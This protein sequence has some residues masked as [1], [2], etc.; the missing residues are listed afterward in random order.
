MCIIRTCVLSVRQTGVMDST[1][2]ST[3]ASMEQ[4]SDNLTAVQERDI[5]YDSNY[6][7]KDTLIDQ[8]IPD[9]ISITRDDMITT[10]SEHVITS[11]T[12]GAI[13]NYTTEPPLIDFQITQS[14]PTSVDC[15]NISQRDVVNSDGYDNETNVHI[16]TDLYDTTVYSS[17]AIDASL[18]E[19]SK[20]PH[21]STPEVHNT[22]YG[23]QEPLIVIDSPADP[24]IFSNQTTCI[25]AAQV[26]A[27]M[28][29]S[30]KE[31][32]E[33]NETPAQ[34][35]VA[36]SVINTIVD[37]TD[38]KE[39]TSNDIDYM[40]NTDSSFDV[41]ES[42]PVY[43]NPI[44]IEGY[45][46]E[47]CP[48]DNVNTYD[49]TSSYNSYTPL[50]ET[51]IA[52]EVPVYTGYTPSVSSDNHAPTTTGHV[53]DDD[54]NSYNSETPLIDPNLPN[55]PFPLPT[56]AQPVYGQQ[57]AVDDVTNKLEEPDLNSLYVTYIEDITGNPPTVNPFQSALDLFSEQQAGTNTPIPVIGGGWE[58]GSICS[59]NLHADV[60]ARALEANPV[61]DRLLSR[62]FSKT[63]GYLE[64][65][66]QKTP[67]KEGFTSVGVCKEQVDLIEDVKI[68][69][70]GNNLRNLLILSISMTLLHI[71][72]YGLRNL[73]SSL[74]TEA[75]LGV[76]SLAATFAAFMIGSLVSPF[77][78]KR[79][80]PRC[81]LCLA[82]SGHLPYI[83]A[84]YYPTFSTMI[85]SSALMGF[86]SAVVWNAICTYITEIGI[87]ESALK[88]KNVGN[89]LSRYF[90]IFFL[91]LQLSVVFGNLI[92][93]IVL[94]SSFEQEDILS[95]TNNISIVF[96]NKTVAAPRHC[97][98]HECNDIIET[99]GKPAVDNMDKL[100]L[101]G[102]YSGCTVI[103]IIVLFLFL[104]PLPSF[105]PQP[106]KASN[107]LRGVGNIVAMVI[108]RKFIF[109]VLLCLY[110]VFSNGFVIAD[111]LKVSRRY[112][113]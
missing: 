91:V 4:M 25:D 54:T 109:I 113:C 34:L 12:T 20:W 89:V 9:E 95:E 56:D 111:V 100:L 26:F 77:L 108:D 88:K 52:I 66:Q 97:G 7:S 3:L 21:S 98:I 62:I 6:L 86:S 73:Q 43:V 59:I 27:N 5:I 92:S 79:F 93:S 76:Y 61:Q 8:S 32:V 36:C 104:D 38:D 16:S 68:P 110:T 96:T 11:P 78:V 70:K 53:S 57:L 85:L 39:Q 60:A 83:V 40:Y 24:S 14:I 105:L 47:D 42:F 82:T 101:L 103:A 87:N 99:G 45:S 13:N 49:G 67:F 33:P 106:I 10:A 2:T 1:L 31:F 102:S 71:A 90:G 48:Q 112:T 22:F 17:T 46:D 72:V 75:G 30:G 65:K 69:A 80:P 37:Q 58:F 15:A 35:T 84:N 94:S 107:V 55:E 44:A 51:S 29:E 18:L 23:N 19:A 81:C 41:N 63:V 28:S 74:N 64:I 50:V